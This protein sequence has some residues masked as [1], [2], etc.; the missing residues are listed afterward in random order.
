MIAQQLAALLG[1]FLGG[2]LPVR[3]VAWDGSATPELDS[4]ER[5]VVTLNS[6]NVLR[7]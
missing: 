2:D 6:P 7:R 4:D 1:P 3:I 5:P